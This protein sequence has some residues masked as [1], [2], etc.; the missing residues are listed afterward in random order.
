MHRL[1]IHGRVFLYGQKEVVV[2]LVLHEQVLGV[3]AG[4][5]VAQCHRFGH[6]EHRLVF[7]GAV[8]DAEMVEKA[9]KLVH[10]LRLRFA[11]RGDSPAGPFFSS[12]L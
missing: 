2:L 8:F 3:T 12:L 5:F 6:G 4:D 11:H 9:E 1:Q 10:G 7:F